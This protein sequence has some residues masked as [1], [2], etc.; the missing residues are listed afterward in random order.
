MEGDWSDTIKHCIGGK[1]IYWRLL[2]LKLLFCSSCVVVGVFA[3]LTL[4]NVFPWQ[5]SLS[6]C[7]DGTNTNQWWATTNEWIYSMLMPVEHSPSPRGLRL[8]MQL[9]SPRLP[10]LSSYCPLFVL[11]QQKQKQKELQKSSFLSD[12]LNHN[13]LKGCLNFFPLTPKINCLPKL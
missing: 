7:S 2:S 3:C 10:P 13:I 12:N 1:A 9:W 6:L 5:S 8:Q 11:I 4:N